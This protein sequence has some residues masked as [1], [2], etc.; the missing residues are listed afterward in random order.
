MFLLAICIPTYNRSESLHKCLFSISK[1]NLGKNIQICISDNS[2]KKINYRTIRKFKKKMNIDYIHNKRNLG[3]V[4]NYLNVIKMAKSKYIWMIGDDDIIL[5]DK[6]RSLVGL[7]K[8]FHFI[9][10]FY[11]NSFFDKKFKKQINPLKL[12]YSEFS[13]SSS[14]NES[15]VM[16]FDELLDPKISNDFLGGMFNIIFKKEKWD[17]YKYLIQKKCFYE[18]SHFKYLE[19]TFPHVKVIANAFFH[20]KVFYIS[21]PYLFSSS[22]YREWKDL[23]PIVNLRLLEIID[24][25][26]KLGLNKLKYIKCKNYALRFYLPD[27]L[28]V[29]IK[30]KNKRFYL[31]MLFKSLFHN[32]LYPNFYLSIIYYVWY[33]FLNLIKWK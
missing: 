7:L 14:L 11:V 16:S 17:R 26:K 15:K 9:D 31:V 24:E 23:S 8:N 28:R 27:V 6:I 20:S 32:F 13:L 33:K 10:L 22:E 18:D 3:R 29:A 12:D 21:K 4:K 25:Y 30:V 1:N 5:N 19:S 2:D